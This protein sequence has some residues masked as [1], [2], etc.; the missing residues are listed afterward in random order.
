MEQRIEKLN[1]QLQRV[2]GGFL[3]S[4]ENPKVKVIIG[5]GKLM[6]SDYGRIA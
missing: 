4:N 2:L 5:G 1:Q 3:H 6:V